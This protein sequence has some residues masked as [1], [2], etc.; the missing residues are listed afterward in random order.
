MGVLLRS[1]ASML[2]SKSNRI[3]EHFNTKFRYEFQYM[4]EV[5][6][7]LEH[8]GRRAWARKPIIEMMVM[9]LVCFLWQPVATADPDL[10]TFANDKESCAKARVL[11]EEA[12]T[13]LD[14]R[15]VI[16]YRGSPVCYQ[17]FKQQGVPWPES[18][19]ELGIGPLHVAVKYNNRRMVTWLIQ[20][21][22]DLLSSQDK[23][24]RRPLLYSQDD[25]MVKFL[26][27]HGATPPEKWDK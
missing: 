1:W 5:E 25:A 18:A 11:L 4:T 13:K 26:L 22:P 27:E 15:K 10:L 23:E 12:G 2:G 17:H 6:M 7:D 20:Q 8:G 21:N 16:A 19:K 3:T 9:L 14:L 24:G